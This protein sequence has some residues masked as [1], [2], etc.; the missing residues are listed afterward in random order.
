M[1]LENAEAGGGRNPAGRRNDDF[2]DFPRDG[3]GRPKIIRA[4]FC[5]ETGQWLVPQDADGK[6]IKELVPFT[7][8][9]TLG[10]AIEYQGGLHRWKSAVVAWGIARSRT[11][12]QA[13]PRGGHVLP[14]GRQG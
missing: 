9:S 10:G 2:A 7:R 1:A 5:E 12:G 8:S 6:P 11:P 13:R 14:P 3:H 4:V